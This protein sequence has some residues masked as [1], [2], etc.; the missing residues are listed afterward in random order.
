[1]GLLYDLVGVC[2]HKLQFTPEGA[3]AFQVG[4]LCQYGIF[5]TPKAG[6]HSDRPLWV[7]PHLP[8]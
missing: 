4:E 2:L 1:M 8:V 6:M 7:A 5:E 3:I